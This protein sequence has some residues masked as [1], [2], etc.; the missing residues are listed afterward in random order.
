M[1]FL[2]TKTCF[3][4][5]KTYGY[6]V[7]AKNEVGAPY[8]LMNYINGDVATEL[9]VAENCDVGLFARHLISGH[10]ITSEGSFKLTNRDFGA[11][12]LL[13][14]NDFEIIGVIDLDGVMAAPIDMVAQYSQLSGRA[15]E[16]PGHIETRPLAIDRISR[17]TPKLEEIQ[18]FRGNNR[19][20]NGPQ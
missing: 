20:R 12:N 11:H 2:Q 1:K 16:P 19:S 17:T 5:P 10:D 7:D 15:R 8:I 3:P 13:V 9:R 4:I 18:E 14:N 6:S